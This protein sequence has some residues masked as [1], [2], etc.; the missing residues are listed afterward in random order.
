MMRRNWKGVLVVDG[1]PHCR[2]TG[3]RC[4]TSDQAATRSKSDVLATA[5][6][7]GACNSWHVDR[8]L[9]GVPRQTEAL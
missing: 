7:C 3:E 1:V 5:Y 2:A 6:Q 8:V 4:F 9:L